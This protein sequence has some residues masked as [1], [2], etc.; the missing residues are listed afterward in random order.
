MLARSPNRK[1]AVAYLAASGATPISVVDRDGPCGIHTGKVT[2]HVAARW[3]VAASDG[4]RVASAAR[5]FAG[6][7]ADVSEAVAAVTRSAKGDAHT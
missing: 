7:D 6:A 3:W 4:V 5:R 1:R 2:G